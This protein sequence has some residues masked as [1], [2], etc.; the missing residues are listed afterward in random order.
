[1]INNLYAIKDEKAMNM[2]QPFLMN[3]DNLAIRGFQTLV[4]DH[5]KSDIS[6]YTADFD[7]FKLGTFNNETGEI[8]SKVEFLCNGANFVKEVE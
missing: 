8:I 6:M 3:N 4:N 1:M 5:G 2:Y 7:L